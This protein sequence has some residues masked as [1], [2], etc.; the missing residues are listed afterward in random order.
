[1]EPC[2]APGHHGY[3]RAVGLIKRPAS[4]AKWVPYAYLRHAFQKLPQAVT[5][6]DVEALL[7]W[8]VALQ[9]TR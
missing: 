7:P 5:L 1:M 3:Q 2:V 8:N 9:A 6:A 4:E